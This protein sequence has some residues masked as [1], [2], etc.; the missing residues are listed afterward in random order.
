[1]K[2]YAPALGVAFCSRPRE[3]EPGHTA[4]AIQSSAESATLVFRTCDCF[5]RRDF[6]PARWRDTFFDFAPHA[7][8]ASDLRK[9]IAPGVPVT[10]LFT[11]RRRSGARQQ[12]LIHFR[13]PAR[14][15]GISTRQVVCGPQ[16]RLG[17][18][19]CRWTRR[20]GCFGSPST[21]R[22]E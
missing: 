19:R 12:G 15:R 10:L 1:R 11:E 14:R 16:Y 7:I 3:C 8:V 6:E 22:H 18:P 17:S 4:R 9:F 21:S 2:S 5:T 20:R 13:V